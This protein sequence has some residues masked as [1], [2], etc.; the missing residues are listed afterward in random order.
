MAIEFVD[1][2]KKINW[3]LVIGGV[4]VLVLLGGGIYALFFAPVP[5]I[6]VIAPASTRSASEL[7]GVKFQGD[8]DAVVKE[9]PP[10]G[11][12]R[13]YV[14]DINVGET[15]RENPFVKY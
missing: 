11:K 14:G 8:L 13:R 3:K 10:Q 5:A 15:G 4:A 6:E 9:F 2:S 7:S 1:E 12:L